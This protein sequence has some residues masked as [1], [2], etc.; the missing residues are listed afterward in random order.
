[1]F[2][3]QA[4]VCVCV[5][6]YVCEHRHWEKKPA[7]QRTFTWV[8]VCMYVM[9]CMYVCWNEKIENVFFLITHTWE[10]PTCHYKIVTYIHTLHETIQ[11]LFYVCVYVC[12]CHV[13][14]LDSLCLCECECVCLCPKWW[15]VTHIHIHVFSHSTYMY[16]FFPG[17]SHCLMSSVVTVLA[18]L[19]RP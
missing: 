13:H 14:T 6:M 10:N 16:L 15:W 18:L 5:C 12:T 17:L 1:M 3:H 19:L 2:F 11:H 7:F 4:Y 8:N 9:Y